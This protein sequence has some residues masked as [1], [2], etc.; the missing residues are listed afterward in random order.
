MAALFDAVNHPT[1]MY[2]YQ[3]IELLS[4][5]LEFQP[6]LILELGR[7]AGNS[8]CAFTEAANRIPGCNV[9][10]I[11]FS[12]DWDARTYPR[13]R[14]VGPQD[15]FKPL[16]ILREDILFQDYSRFLKGK[17]R[18][19]LF[20]DAHGFDVAECILGGIMP[21]IKDKKHVVMMH[22]ISDTRYASLEQM[23]Y[24]GNRLWRGNNWQGP[25]L[26]IGSIDSCVEQAIAILDFTTR[27]RVHLHSADHDLHTWFGEHAD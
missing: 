5:A 1:D 10:S 26:M 8:T 27:N 6:D 22:D 16:S 21:L 3:W 4:F 24:K 14:K 7:G 25:R 13:V 2:L 18:V 15:W 12:D 19:M 9:V 17:E 23:D 11:C 20:W